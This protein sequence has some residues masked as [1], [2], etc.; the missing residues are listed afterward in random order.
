MVNTCN[1]YIRV[2]DVGR[3]L[4]PAGYMHQTEANIT[5]NPDV[6]MT[7]GSSK[8]QGIH[9]AGTG[10]LIK[11]KAAFVST[12]PDYEFMKEKFSWMRATLV[13]TIESATQTL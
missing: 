9:G 11:G 12:G 6:L 1:S 13:I 5:H 8:V 2:T 7:L 10:F 4:I 3:L